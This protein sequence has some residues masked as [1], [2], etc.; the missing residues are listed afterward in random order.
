MSFTPVIMVTGAGGYLGKQAVNALRSAS[1]DVLP[2]DNFSMCSVMTDVHYGDVRD[3]EHMAHLMR[4][5]KVDAVIHFAGLKSVVK[6]DTES[7]EYF[8]NNVVGTHRLLSAMKRTGV[9]RI[10]YSSSAA[11]YGVPYTT[12]I[13]ENA[14]LHPQSFY[15]YTKVEAER[16]IQDFVKEDRHHR[17][18]AILRYFNPIGGHTPPGDSL[19]AKLFEEVRNPTE[20]MKLYGEGLP[21]RDYIFTDDLMDGHLSALS[22]ILGHDGHHVWNLGTGQS[23]TVLEVVKEVEKITG[24]TIQGHLLPLRQ[25]EVLESVANP[26]LAAAQLRWKATTSLHDMIKDAWEKTNE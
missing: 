7:N 11:V 22:Y 10:V 24:V 18:S 15:G 12:P 17:S 3:E 23:H 25:G 6:G 1:F 9:N 5:Y 8:H 13:P 26:S 4:T 16:R 19:I 21:R 20:S 14:E 2:V